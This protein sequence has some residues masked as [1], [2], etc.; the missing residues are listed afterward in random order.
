MTKAPGRWAGKGSRHERGYGSAWVKL[1]RNILDRD[2]HLC[3]PCLAKGR[4]TPAPMVDH[5]VAKADGGTDDPSN[6]R[7]ICSACHAAKTTAE[8]HAA[9]GHTVRE[10]RT[11]GPD[12]WPVE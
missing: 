3:Q 11:I 1:R 8:G 5:I 6:L 10:R 4:P 12:G 7:A 2:M 9:A